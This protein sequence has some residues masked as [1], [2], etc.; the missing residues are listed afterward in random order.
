[1]ILLRVNSSSSK[2]RLS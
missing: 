2:C 1:M